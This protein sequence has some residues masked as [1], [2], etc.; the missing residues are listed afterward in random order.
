[1]TQYVGTDD[2]VPGRG[3]RLHT[4]DL[5]RFRDDHLVI[6]DRIK[7][8]IIRGRPNVHPRD[9]ERAVHEHPDV[10]EVAVVGIPHPDLGEVPVGAVVLQP[11]WRARPARTSSRG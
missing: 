2:P 6:V 5:G 11:V 10:L 8:L 4:G 7:D 1:M 9:V 3:G